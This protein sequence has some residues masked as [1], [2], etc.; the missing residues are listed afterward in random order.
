[1]VDHSS[2]LAELMAGLTFFRQER[3]VDGGIRTGIMLGVETVFEKFEI[4]GD[5]Y[6][7][8]LAWSVDLRCNG[9]ILPT[10]PS[11]AK[12][13]FLANERQIRDGL[14]S[15]AEALSVGID[16]TGIQLPE[17]SDFH[18]LPEGV[19]M[20]IVC[21]ALRRIDALYLATR[22]NFIA[23]NWVDLVQGLETTLHEAY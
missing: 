18:D 14:L 5:E 23:Q 8:S 11:D 9:S 4:A 6:D 12:A 20:K 22:L 15:Y 19:R 13:W 17:W 10:S 1:M 3:R 7:P 21:G 16:P 2:I